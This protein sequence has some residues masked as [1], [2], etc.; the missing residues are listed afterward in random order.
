MMIPTSYSL[1]SIKNP[2]QAPGRRNNSSALAVAK[3][4]PGHPVPL[5]IVLGNLLCGFPIIPPFIPL[6]NHVFCV[7][8]C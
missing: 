1:T 6:N 5:G 2:T 8:K 7:V 3:W 4:P